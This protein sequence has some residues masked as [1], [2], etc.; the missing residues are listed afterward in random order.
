MVC[1]DELWNGVDVDFSKGKW[2]ALKILLAHE[3][4]A[5]DFIFLYMIS[6]RGHFKDVWSTLREDRSR[7]FSPV[8]YS[9]SALCLSLRTL[10]DPG[11]LGEPQMPNWGGKKRNSLYFLFICGVRITQAQKHTLW[12]NFSRGWV[13]VFPWSTDCK[14]LKNPAFY[15]LNI[16]VLKM[17]LWWRKEDGCPFTSLFSVYN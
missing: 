10:Q 17:S 16:L 5:C 4:K 6:M 3:Q 13:P 8:K 15:F 7:A 1:F 11:A 12:S 9:A 2:L 14:T